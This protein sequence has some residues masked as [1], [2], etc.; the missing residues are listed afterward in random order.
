MRLRIIV[1]ACFAA[2]A[3]GCHSPTGPPPPTAYVVSI[4]L[5]GPTRFAPTSSPKFTVTAT[6]SD[7]TTQDYTTKAM[8][9]A[10]SSTFPSPLSVTSTGVF[11]IR[12]VG[13][14]TVQAA[15]GALRSSLNVMVIPDGT[16]RLIGTVSEAGLP[17]SP[18]TV[19]VV[20]GTGMGLS[21]TTDSQGNYRLYGVAGAIQ[22]QVSKAGYDP[23]IN[24]ITVST[25][26]VLDFPNMSETGGPAAVAGTYSLSIIAGSDCR[27]VNGTMA[28]E[29]AYRS[30]TYTAVVTENGPSLQVALSG[31]NFLVQNGRGN[32]LAGR[33]SPG[34]ASFTLRD[35][36]GYYYYYYYSV[37]SPD[38]VEQVGQT[39]ALSFWGTAD[40]ALSPA[41]L[42][43]SF[44]GTIVVY[45]TKTLKMLETCESG[46][47]QFTMTPMTSTRRKR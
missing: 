31:A 26:N 1:L 25:D 4:K 36:G 5:D 11:T 12:S 38:V 22:V 44:A 41:G 24:T 30:R 20:A 7:K 3:V 29:A 14:A 17:V 47:T 10:F 33:V 2:G 37:G 15:F 32:Q 16:Y 34:H 42:T 18:A 45:D 21:T 13:E 23:A 8:W 35:T 46:A 28:L 39:T 27:L 9:F 19:A 40:T 6:M 43:G